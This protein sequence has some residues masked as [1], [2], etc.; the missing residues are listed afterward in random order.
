MDSDYCV[1]KEQTMSLYDRLVGIVKPKPKVMADPTSNADAPGKFLNARVNKL[2]HGLNLTLPPA[3][4]NAVGVQ[5]FVIF[6]DPDGTIARAA[7]AFKAKLPHSIAFRVWQNDANQ[8]SFVPSQDEGRYVSI[9]GNA[10]VLN[11][12]KHN[13][14]RGQAFLVHSSDNLDD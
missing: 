13:N 10:S 11:R 6:K 1:A 7:K 14:L 2:T 5:G 12:L 9:R 3:P 8:D 4:D